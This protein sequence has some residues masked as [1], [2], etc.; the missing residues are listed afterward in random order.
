MAL[1]LASEISSQS[2]VKPCQ[3]HGFRA[4]PSQEHHYAAWGVQ[5][6]S[7]LER[8]RVQAELKGEPWLQSQAK[9]RTSL[10]SVGRSA[11]FHHK[12][13]SNQDHPLKF[14]GDCDCIRPNE[15]SDALRI[16]N[17]N[18]MS[19]LPRKMV[20]IRAQKSQ[21]RENEL[22]KINGPRPKYCKQQQEIQY[23]WGAQK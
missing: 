16:F 8:V 4:K 9:P 14:P 12:T 3:S 7:M 11:R 23:I 13:G 20:E 1:A 17:A 5:V 18:R 19:L 15:A 22:K 21:S 2:Q 10:C 6:G